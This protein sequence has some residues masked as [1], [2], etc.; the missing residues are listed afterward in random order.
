[1]K[2]ERSLQPITEAHKGLIF[3]AALEGV[4]VSRCDG[5]ERYIGYGD[6]KYGYGPACI[7]DFIGTEYVIEPHVTWFPWTTTKNRIVNFKWALEYLSKTKQILLTVQK[8]EN[9]FF[10][11]FVEKGIL[12]KVGVIINLPIVEEIHMY[13]YEKVSHE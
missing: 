11:H 6:T 4:D 5:A 12:R 9:L 13:Q 8:K 7:A 1:M 3:A 10:E 2:L